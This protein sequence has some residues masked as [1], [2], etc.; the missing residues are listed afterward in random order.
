MVIIEYL[1][2]HKAAIDVTR[3]N[4]DRIQAAGINVPAIRR[5]GDG[6]FDVG[7]PDEGN[8]LCLLAMSQAGQRHNQNA[9]TEHIPKKASQGRAL[10]FVRSIGRDGTHVTF[11]LANTYFDIITRLVR[12]RYCPAIYKGSEAFVKFS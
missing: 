5:T 8:K 2:S 11:S 1:L 3:K 6:I 10:I 4:D 7:I 9:R 12:R